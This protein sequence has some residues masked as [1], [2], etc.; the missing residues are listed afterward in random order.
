[1]NKQN[2]ETWELCYVNSQKCMNLFISSRSIQRVGFVRSQKETLQTHEGALTNGRHG[3][4]RGDGGKAV[5]VKIGRK[6]SF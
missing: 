2:G 4:G 6:R 5:R 3:G 1:M